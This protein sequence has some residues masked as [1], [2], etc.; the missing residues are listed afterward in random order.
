MAF[1]KSRGG[2]AQSTS[3][4]VETQIETDELPNSWKKFICLRGDVPIKKLVKY[5]DPAGNKYKNLELAKDAYLQMK[6][7]IVNN[8]NRKLSLPSNIYDIPRNLRHQSGVSGLNTTLNIA[9]SNQRKSLPTMTK[10]KSEPID[11]KNALITNRVPLMQS[12]HI[13]NIAY[14]NESN[15][16]VHMKNRHGVDNSPSVSL[17][18]M[19]MQEGYRPSTSPDN[20]SRTN[21]GNHPDTS[22]PFIS[23]EYGKFS[24]KEMR[25]HVKTK[26]IHTDKPSRSND[27]FDTLPSK[28]SHLRIVPN[29]PP[30]PSVNRSGS[31]TPRPRSLSSKPS[32]AEG[33]NLRIPSPFANNQ[34][35]YCDECGIEFSSPGRKRDH[36]EQMHG[37]PGKIV[38]SRGIQSQRNSS[39]I[40]DVEDLNSPEEN[41]VVIQ[42]EPVCE[43]ESMENYCDEEEG[44][45]EL[46]DES[47]EPENGQI[48][49]ED[50]EED[51]DEEFYEAEENPEEYSDDEYYQGNDLNESEDNDIE[52]I[53]SGVKNLAKFQNDIE[54]I[55]DKSERPIRNMIKPKAIVRNLSLDSL[56]NRYSQI[57]I[58]NNMRNYSDDDNTDEDEDEGI[59]QVHDPEE[60]TLDDEPEEVTLDECD[61]EDE[62]LM[63]TE[64]SIEQENMEK[65]KNYLM[66]LNNTEFVKDMIENPDKLL[67]F[68]Q[69]AWYA[70][71]SMW[72]PTKQGEVWQATVSQICSYFQLKDFPLEHNWWFNN[73]DSF[74]KFFTEVLCTINPEKP[75][76]SLFK[77]KKAKWFQY[78]NPSHTG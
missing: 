17:Q 62:V 26:T 66:M 46:Q 21:V 5:Q 30:G 34:I 60:I 61:E 75:E 35:F 32:I 4:W 22:R 11:T 68:N 33:S 63:Q 29:A 18:Q 13:C 47:M 77:L 28:P 43:T 38:D 64:E 40:E 1:T 71:P 57:T 25:K 55:E 48:W 37:S 65:I 14:E 7:V 16:K 9:Q 51:D 3:R 69:N 45:D 53:S 76:S 73:W 24:K 58:T 15:L 52:V 8:D 70:K 56:K 19:A 67:G 27:I 6:A 72:K 78:L 42:W 23:N 12:C 2:D 74:D 50:D 10:H 44:A 49:E 31:A 54:V 41:G 36:V 59:S 20:F 39:N